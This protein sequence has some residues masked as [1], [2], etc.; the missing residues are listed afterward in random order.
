MKKI[1]K[2]FVVAGILI[3]ANALS[4]ML[5]NT[6]DMMKSCLAEVKVPLCDNNFDAMVAELRVVSMDARGEFVYVL[7]DVL[8]KEGS[9][10]V[11]LNLYDKLKVLVPVYTNLD[12]TSNWSGRDMLGLASQV[13]VEYLKHSSIDAKELENLF[14]QQKTQTARYNFMI[15]VHNKANKLEEKTEID[16]L[17]SFGELAKDHIKAQGDEYY[18]FQTAVDLVK[19][20]TVKNMKNIVGFEGVYEIELKDE[21]AAKILKVDHLVIVVADDRNGLVVNFTSSKL[22]STKFSFK[23]AGLLGNTAFSNDKVYINSNELVSPGF[24]FDMDFSSGTV[25]GTFFSK[26]FG[27]VEFVGKQKINNS[28]LYSTPSDSALELK[29]VVGVYPLKV[30]KYSMILKISMNE[31]GE[32]EASLVNNNALIVFSKLRFNSEFNVLK[33]LDWQLKNVLEVKMNMVNDVL[34]ISGQFTNSNTAKVL[35]VQN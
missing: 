6:M 26:R 22:R 33:A 10:E 11:V 27:A 19:K 9:K 18:V 31:K 13:S 12:G 32:T 23:G 5:N 25:S 24:K 3:Q 1:M 35:D 7:K 2:L 20:L 4:P 34:D 29:D 30:G 15:E 14:V 16:E 8:K 21:M 17:I 28:M